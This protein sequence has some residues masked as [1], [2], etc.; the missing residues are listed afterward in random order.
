MTTY[1]EYDISPWHLLPYLGNARWADAEDMTKCHPD[2]LPLTE[3]K[4]VPKE[5]ES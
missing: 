2:A 5:E 3:L 4:L 1:D